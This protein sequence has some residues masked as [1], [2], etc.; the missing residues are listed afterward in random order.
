MLPHWYFSLQTW[1]NR[2]FLLMFAVGVGLF[3]L[4]HDDS[5]IHGPSIVLAGLLLFCFVASIGR[6]RRWLFC[7]GV[8]SGV[9][10]T[11]AIFP[12]IREHGWVALA[13]PAFPTVIFCWGALIAPDPRGVFE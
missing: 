7:A 4:A 8:V 3:G 13:F 10:I 1:V 12:L 6:P 2:A 11:A 9:F 5:G